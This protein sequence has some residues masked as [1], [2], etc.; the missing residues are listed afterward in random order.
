MEQLSDRVVHIVGLAFAG[1]ALPV[2]VVLTVLWR[3]DLAGLA[4]VAIYGTSFVTMLAASLAYNHTSDPDRLEPLRKF[5]L[6]A[7]YLKI[8]GTVTP[9]ALLSGQGL[10]FLAVLWAVALTAAATVFV[11]PRRTGLQSVVIC[12]AMGWAVLLGGGEVLAV[13]PD[14]VF[15]MML[16]G[17]ILY[18]AGTPF[19]LAGGV[20]FHNTIWHG[21]VVTASIVFFAAITAYLAAT[22]G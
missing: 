11:G 12:L 9:F 10:V 14:H 22:S 20:R 1:A 18:S 16:A 4:A 15:W 3:G 5:D 13:L 2:L 21:F 6:A 7:I 19:L 17:G 8:A